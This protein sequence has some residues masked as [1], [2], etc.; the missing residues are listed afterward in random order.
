[1][2]G[3]TS[4]G[5]H[6]HDVIFELNNSPA[7]S[8]ASRGEVRTIVLALKFLEVDIIEQFTGLKPL[9]LLDDVFSELDLERQK[10]LSDTIRRHQIVITSTHVLSNTKR[11]K[12][13]KLDG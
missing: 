5:P 2:L 4:V 11:F 3:N 6:R 12:H 10:S 7:L 9:I 1:M 8:V 13:V